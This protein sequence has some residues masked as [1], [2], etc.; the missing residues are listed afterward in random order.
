MSAMLTLGIT[1]KSGSGKSTLARHLKRRRCKVVDVDHLAQELYAPGGPAYR[2]L[3]RC[4][5]PQ[6]YRADGRVDRAWLGRLVFSRPN[7]LAALNRI[8]FPLIRKALRARIRLEK[9]RKTRLLAF[10]MAVLFQA[11]ADRLMDAVLLVEAPLELRIR[12]LR[13]GRAL[14]AR[15]ARAQAQALR[16]PKDA[17][18]RAALVLQNRGSETDLAEQVDAFLDH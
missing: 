13:A 11:G 5:G 8:M 2:A 18:A 3:G 1:G 10:D 9:A 14:D 7:H 17:R 16:M 4:F 6:V 12:R 15:R